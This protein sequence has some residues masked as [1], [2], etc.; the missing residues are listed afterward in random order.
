M[1][2]VSMS[3]DQINQ[4]K[5]KMAVDGEISHEEVMELLR[6][7]KGLEEMVEDASND[8][9]FGTEGWERMMWGD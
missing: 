6:Y 1:A 4:V 9:F 3:R 5:G 7:I 2:F 8:D